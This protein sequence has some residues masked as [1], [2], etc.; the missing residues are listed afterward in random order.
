[1]LN[2]GSSKHFLFYNRARRRA[3]QL[4]ALLLIT[5]GS[6]AM[7]AEWYAAPNGSGSDCT[8]ASPCTIQGAIDKA[9]EYDTVHV[10]SGDYSFTSNRIV[11]DKAGL[12]LIGEASPFDKE[13]ATPPG[14]GQ[15]AHGTMGNVASNAVALKGASSTASGDDTSGMIWVKNVPD[16]E[17]RNLYVEVNGANSF[18]LGCL[19]LVQR[20]KEGIVATGAVNGLKLD[21]NYVKAV[22]GTSI[23]GISI[24][25]AASGDS[26]VP[27]GEA[28]ASAQYVEITNNVVEPKSAGSSS[29]A[30]KR[31]IAMQNSAGLLQGNQVAGHTQD[32]WLQNSKGG[33][34]H[35]LNLRDN[36]FFGRLQ[37]YMS[38]RS[39]LTENVIE[40]NHF[41]SSTVFSLGPGNIFSPGYGNGSEAHGLRIM[42][43]GNVP[44]I[45]RNN[46]FDGFGQALRALWLQ[47]AAETVIE[48]NT[49][50]PASWQS[51]FTAIAVGNREVWNGRPAPRAFDVTIRGNTLDRKSVV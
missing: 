50:T 26:S 1:M 20:A 31:A 23:I 30:F 17:I 13:Y 16:V 33:N 25:L 29:S 40:A 27:S 5:A 39:G 14:P 36:W 42:G 15:V 19:C 32:M 34:A 12:K 49:F 43:N 51:D 48:G 24:N 7:T 37:V 45:V 21:N 10:A 18:D 41:D 3:L 47:N 4:A 35:P 8:E 44:A 9:G 38:G 46:F 22:G 28:R 11:I 6:G 2:R